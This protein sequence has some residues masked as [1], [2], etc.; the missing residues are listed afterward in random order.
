MLILPIAIPDLRL[1]RLSRVSACRLVSRLFCRLL[2]NILVSIMPVYSRAGLA[3]F[4][5]SSLQAA[6]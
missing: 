5:L 2:N 6:I 4:C 1:G 3:T